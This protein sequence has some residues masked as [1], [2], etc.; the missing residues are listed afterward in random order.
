MP[1]KERAD[2]SSGAVAHAR[3]MLDS[4]P[5]GHRDSPQ[6]IAQGVLHTAF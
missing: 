3:R 6:D 4:T 1:Q 2:P 5:M